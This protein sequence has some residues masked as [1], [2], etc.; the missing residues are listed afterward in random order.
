MGEGECSATVEEQPKRPRNRKKHLYNTILQQMEFYFSDANLSKDR[1]LSTIISKDRYV[2]IEQFQKFNKIKKLN[3]TTEDIRKAV[4][5]SKLIETSEDGLKLCRKLPIKVKEDETL[6]TIYVENI[7][8]DATHETL[9]Q[10]FSDFGKIAYISIPKYAHKVNKGF[11]FIEYE[12]P[13]EADQALAFFNSI[14]CQMPS[15]KCPE[16]L[17]SVRTYEEPGTVEN[18]DENVETVPKI[19]V[20]TVNENIDTAPDTGD[21]VEIESDQSASK[22]EGKTKE[23]KEKKRKLSEQTDVPAKKPKTDEE[24]IVSKT[25]EE[26]PSEKRKL[27]GQKD[28]PAKRRKTDEEAQV[29]ENP[30][31]AQTEKCE[32]RKKKKKKKEK[33]KNMVKELGLQVLSKTEWKRLRNNYL[34]LQRKKMRELK[35]YLRQQKY[36]PNEQSP[37]FADAGET[38]EHGN[39]KIELETPTE[40]T[41]LAYVSGVIVK[42]KLLEQC[43]DV[44]KLKNDIKCVAPD[45]NYVDIPLPCGSEEVFIRFATSE[46][47][48]E[49]CEKDFDGEKTIL[50]GDEEKAYW[51]KIEND[52]TVKF[53]KLAKKQ[54]GRDKLLKKAEKEAA[55]HLRFDEKPN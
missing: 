40:A 32:K 47:A 50:E 39:D 3:C 55:K 27:S 24:T 22:V 53:K 5:N 20:R 46:A 11:A 28:V 36:G 44:K 12:T 42:L 38:A 4:R 34:N 37:N 16:E 33:K 41:K 8:A 9:S 13:Q 14:G 26:T 43:S 10:I 6:C 54:R 49:F 2:E 1:F 31:D 18:V 25:L 21:N 51:E 29:S 17:Q 19:H 7:K 52:R 45:V 15:S 48:S 23:G 35:L 30:E